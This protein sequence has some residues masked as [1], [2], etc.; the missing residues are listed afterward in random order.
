M[1]FDKLYAKFEFLLNVAPDMTHDELEE[2][3]AYLEND[4]HDAGEMSAWKTWSQ[5]LIEAWEK[6]NGKSFTED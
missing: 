6:A 4:C 3:L 5:D 2:E 1:N